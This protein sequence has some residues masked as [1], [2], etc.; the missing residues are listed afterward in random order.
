MTIKEKVLASAKTSFAKYGL[1][2]DELSRLADQIVAN[3]GLTDESKDEDVTD[4][5]TAFEPVVGLMQSMFNRAVSETGKKY[6]GWI[7]PTEPKAKPIE[8]STPTT[9]QTGMLTAEQVQKMIAESVANNQ[10]A[11]DDAVATALAPFKER[12]ERTRLTSLL[13]DNPKIKDIPEV[14]RSRYSLDKEDN[15]DATLQK[16]TDDWVT[17]K[18]SLVSSGQYIEAPRAASVSQAQDDF[19][20]KMQGFAERNTP[21]QN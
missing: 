13:Q 16:I 19:A 5:I 1:K 17:T 8:S 11:I 10:K 20:K 6:E 4:A 3:R 7:A 12:E 18:Q 14:F 21:K 9:P 15:L 2:K